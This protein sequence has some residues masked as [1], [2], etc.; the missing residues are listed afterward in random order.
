MSTKKILIAGAGPAGIACSMVLSKNKI[1]HIIIDKQNFPRDKICGDALSGK[2]VQE[3][4][5]IDPSYVD[6]ISKIATQYSG[7]YGVRFFAPNGK[8]L[9]VPFSNNPDK[10]KQAPGFIATRLNFDNFLFSKLNREFVTVHENTSLEKVRRSENSWW[11][12]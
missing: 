5:K 1:D 8:M 11:Q 3:L 4:N 10:S 9:D 7:S 12:N 2:V 6:E